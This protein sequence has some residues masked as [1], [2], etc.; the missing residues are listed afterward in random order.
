MPKIKQNIILFMAEPF[1]S[2]DISLKA[3]NM[4]LNR[5]CIDEDASLGLDG[6]YGLKQFSNK[7]QGK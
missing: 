7:T 2:F 5:F 1:N 6:I 3:G 4:C